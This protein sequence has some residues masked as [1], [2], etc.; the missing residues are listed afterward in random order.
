[1]ILKKQ[2][3]LRVQAVEEENDGINFYFAA[4]NQAQKFTHFLHTVVP[5]THE[6]SSKLISHNERD[7]TA[8][9]KMT[10][11]YEIAPICRD[12]LV[13]LPIK[14]ARQLGVNQLCLV[15]RVSNQIHLYDLAA[16][17]YTA[18][19]SLLY[20]KSYTYS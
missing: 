15:L 20:H 13:I 16:G 11:V 6:K 14:A 18:M 19:T 5:G 12:D 4:H 3:S 10:F 7:A 17:V 8:N 1:I 9:I 2:A